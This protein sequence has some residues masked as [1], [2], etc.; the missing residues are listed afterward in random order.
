M[1]ELWNIFAEITVQPD[2]FASGNTVG[3]MNIITWADTA[4]TAQTKIASYFDSFGW[5]I[6]SVEAAKVLDV[7]HTC[8]NEEFQD[9]IARASVNPEAILCGTFHSYKVN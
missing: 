6:V 9:I 1:T 4:E 5:H 3:F 8:E 2:D 7:D